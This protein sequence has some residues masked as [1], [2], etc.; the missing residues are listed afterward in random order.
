VPPFDGRDGYASV[1]IEAAR[2]IE[3]R[4][5]LKPSEWAERHRR[6]VGKSSAEPGPWSNDRI[7]F[8]RDIMDALDPSHP[9][10]LVVFCASSQVGKSETGLN[11][12]GSRIMEAPASILALFP[13]EKVARKWIRARLDPM[14]AITPELR[15][16]VPLGRRSQEG[17]TLSEKHFRDGVL[18]TGSAGIPDDVAS[19]SVQ[20]LLCD[21]V[22]RMPIVLEDEGDPVELA[23]R[24]LTTYEGRSKAFMASTPTVMATSK[25]WRYL[26]SSTFDRYFVPCPHCNHL[27][28]LKWARLQW[29]TGKPETAMYVC[30]AEDC[31]AAIDESAKTDMLAAGQWRASFPEREEFVKG[32]HIN[33]LY[34]PRGLGDPWSAHAAAWER[35]QGKPGAVQVF[36]NTRLGEPHAGEQQKVDWD[37]VA[38][39]REPWPLR[40]VPRG[41]LVL[42][43]GTDVQADRLET[44]VLGWGRGERCR[45]IDYMVHYGDPS[46]LEV[47]L[48]LE[49]YLLTPFRT[50]NGRQLALSCSMVDAGYLPNDVLGFTRPRK[51]RGIFA[52]RGSRIRTR[53]AIGRPSYPD[54]KRKRRNAQPDKRG[55][56][57]YEI[58]VHV[59]KDW[60]HDRLL[61]DGGTPDEPLAPEQRRIRFP[62]GIKPDG[63]DGL[64]D[65]YFRQLTSETFD[66]KTQ[67]WVEKA[68]YH[69]EE[70]RDTMI[71]ARGAA[72]HHRVAIHRWTEDDWSAIEAMLEPAPES[73]D[74]PPSPAPSGTSAARQL[75]DGRATAPKP[76][77]GAPNL[78]I[79]AIVKKE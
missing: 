27:Q 67:Q 32:F 11:W 69:K 57:L 73:T 38:G 10:P 53:Q 23:L 14:I 43:S 68:N 4:I 7:P 24:R 41:T 71:Y 46:A 61:R 12:I 26:I 77:S 49:R 75:P 59:I 79:S 63:S 60:L 13:T 64:P 70:A 51:A 36:F 9:A 6:L 19:V 66:A 42:T 76:A 52:C 3:P 58:G 39:R 55:A 54:T 22:D 20:Y 21:E 17:S 50:W 25:I 74:N 44:Q 35:A 8:L 5:A 16:L 33:G 1:L 31:G 78:P 18:Y 29:I 34:T 48:D 47:W 15:R 37:T 45:V 72:L 56:E 65:E 62:G 30:E 2:L 40:V 28:F